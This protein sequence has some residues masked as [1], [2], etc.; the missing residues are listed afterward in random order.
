MDQNFAPSP[1]AKAARLYPNAVA[2]KYQTT[3]LTYRVLNQKVLAL[4]S[5]LK[6]K[7]NDKTPLACIAPN[8]IELVLLY[9]TCIELGRVFFPISPR[10]AP[11]QITALLD[12]Y[13][14]RQ[15]WML[16]EENSP[17]IRVDL[18][19]SV[20]L[21][22]LDFG[23]DI[24]DDDTSHQDT[25]SNRNC[26][27]HAPCNAILTSGSSGLPKAALHNLANHVANAIGARHL[28]QLEQQDAWLLSLPLFHIGGLAVLNRCALAGATVVLPDNRISLAAQLQRDAITHLSL[29]PAQLVKILAESATSLS[30]LKALLLGGGAVEPS[31]ITQL[32]SALAPSKIH[33]YTSYGMTE[34]ASQI[35]TGDAGTPGS[36]QLLPYREL[37]I[38]DGVI[39]VRGDCLFLGYLTPDGTVTRDCDEQGWFCT[40]DCGEWDDEGHLHILGRTDNMFICGGENIQPEEVEAALKRH[41]HIA[42]AIVFAEPDEQFGCLPSAIIQWKLPSLNNMHDATIAPGI[43]QDELDRFLDGKIARFKPPRRYHP[44]PITL[45]L[46]GLKIPRKQIIAAVTSAK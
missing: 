36:G 20:Q 24:G 23:F 17:P 12:T 26:D 9:W 30:P 28:I 32:D 21:I 14:L 15:L 41:P 1:L 39:W 3:Q 33:A 31:I 35:T 2:V 11:E 25:A 7:G 22:S 16:K 29:V 42:E 46:T 40:Q 27:Y 45:K 34:M 6:S 18:A 37:Q 10:F 43:T 5:Q 44:W 38:R 8:C 19:N 13:Q 4:A